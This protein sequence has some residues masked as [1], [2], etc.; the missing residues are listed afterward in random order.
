LWLIYIA[1]NIPGTAGRKS[2]IISYFSK[3]LSEQIQDFKNT[4]KRII[5][6][7]IYAHLQ[8]ESIQFFIANIL[9]VRH[10]MENL[11]RMN[12]TK[13]FIKLP[14][15]H[16][17]TFIEDWSIRQPDYIGLLY[18][19]VI[20]KAFIGLYESV[21]ALHSNG[22]TA[23]TKNIYIHPGDTVISAMVEQLLM[24]MCGL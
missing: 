14:H 18:E 20:R 2:N 23:A 15:T 8:L 11:D 13:V 19:S 9:V 4:S 7:H 21:I 3:P 24:Y 5:I 1:H 12:E 6:I 22:I 10:V 17:Q 16:R